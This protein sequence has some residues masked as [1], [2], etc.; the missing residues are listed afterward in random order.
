MA[1]GF[2]EWSVQE[3]QR[4]LWDKILLRKPKIKTR[5]F[6]GC[7]LTGFFVEVK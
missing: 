2:I 7:Y 4:N 3:D 5:R 6:I 1:S